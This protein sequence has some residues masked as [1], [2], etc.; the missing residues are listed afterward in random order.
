MLDRPGVRLAQ[1][2]GNPFQDAVRSVAAAAGLRFV[3]NAVLDDAGRLI[4]VAYGDPVA[5]HDHLTGIARRLSTV[6]IPG[7]VEIAV[8]GVG[9]PKDVNLYQASRAASYLQF[10]PTPVV[11]PGGVLIVPA[12][13]PEG[14]GEGV[15]ERRFEEAMSTHRPA[16]IVRDARL[17]G[18]RPGEQRAYVMARVLEEVTVIF[19]GLDE[20]AVAER[21]GFQT[22]ASVQDALARA[23]ETVGTP[24]NALLVPHALLTLPVVAGGAD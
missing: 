7:Q 16:E 13:C 22:A 3:A 6:T 14:A 19:V 20:P 10:A 1:I 12:T 18:I 9:S 8:A 4:A 5:V 2:E 17:H 23:V 11:R 21:M 24:A 15:G